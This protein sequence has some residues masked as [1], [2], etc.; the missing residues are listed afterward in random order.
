M[1]RSGMH[2]RRNSMSLADAPVAKEGFSVT[3]FL[4][5]KDRARSREFY[6]WVLGAKVV[7][8]ENPCCLKVANSWILLNAGGG[9][10]PAS[11][12]T[13]ADGVHL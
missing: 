2:R 8:P 12:L 9:P 7:L 5:V 3:H 6:V 10:T 1:L 11:M 13:K 4:T